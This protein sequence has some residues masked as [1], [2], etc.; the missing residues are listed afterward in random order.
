MSLFFMEGRL[1]LVP[2]FMGKG[3]SIGILAGIALFV[4]GWG[5]AGCAS[6]SST[7]QYYL[8][9]TTKIYPPKDKEA[10]IPIL[11]QRPKEPYKVIGRLTFATDLGWSFLRKSMIYNARIN[12][13]DAVILES[14]KTRREEFFTDV[15]PQTD[16]IPV[17]NYVRN[18]NNDDVRTYTSWVP[19]FRPGYVRRNVVEISAIDSEMIVLKK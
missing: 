18:R 10:V 8:S 12:G 4:L 5:L 17:Q 1:L 6:V 11:N 13:A 14:L 15:P 16:W 2:T 19:I 9:A 7:S 3:N